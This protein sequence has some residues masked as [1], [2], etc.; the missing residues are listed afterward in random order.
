VER[1]KIELTIQ[2]DPDEPGEVETV[3]EG[4]AKGMRSEALFALWEVTRTAVHHPA[5]LERAK[6]DAK[7]N[8][9][10]LRK[11]K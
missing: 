9:S 11:A 5:A 3:A 1:V 10:P 4:L 2:L 6:T 7:Q 8:V